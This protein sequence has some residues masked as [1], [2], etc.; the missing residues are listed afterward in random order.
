MSRYLLLILLSY[1]V[2]SGKSVQAENIIQTKQVYTYEN[3]MSDL[4]TL[5]NK[6]PDELEFKTIG[7]SHLNRNIEAIKLGHGPKNVLL[8]GAHHGREWLT[9]LLLMKMLETYTDSYHND[10]DYGTYT[11]DIFDRV[12]LWFVPMMNPD[13]VTLQQ[14]GLQQFPINHQNLLVYMN[15]GSY[16]FK[17]WKANAMGID[18]NRQYPAGWDELEGENTSNYQFYKGTKPFQ[19]METIAIAKFTQELNPSIAIAYHTAGREIF[20][21][22]N[23][24]H[25]M[26][27]D[28]MIAR[29]VSKLTGYKLANPPDTSKGGGFTDWFITTFHKP[30][31]TIEIGLLVGETNP[32]LSVF[33]EEWNRNKFVGLMLAHEAEK[34]P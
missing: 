34:L 15:K 21:K 17:R 5:K 11:T 12:S 6:Y 30:A 23:N 31:M 26:K 2:F 27:R 18:L 28:R 32:P 7:S 14:S 33:K 3:L 29:K 1:I 24:G 16:D 25:L 4:Q 19:A 8:I 13:G 20:W 22:F 10:N 9:T